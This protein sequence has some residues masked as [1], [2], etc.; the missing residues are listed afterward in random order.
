MPKELALAGE[1][2]DQRLATTP[3]GRQ[4][5]GQREQRPERPEADADQRPEDCTP[6][7][8]RQNLPAHDRAQQ[9]GDGHN[10][11]QRRH[12]LRRTVAFVEI[13]H[14]GAPSTTPAQAPTACTMRHTIIA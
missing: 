11:H 12:H 5:L 9:G 4:R 1:R 3:P 6:T 13:A 8:E 2:A 10:G 7:R 14:H